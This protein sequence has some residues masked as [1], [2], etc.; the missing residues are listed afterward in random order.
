MLPARAE[1]YYLRR[2]RRKYACRGKG[3]LVSIRTYLG[4]RVEV[5]GDGAGAHIVLWPRGRISEQTVVTNA[6]SRGVGAYGISPYYL[7]RPPR[8]GIRLGYSRLREPQIREGIRRLA[9]VI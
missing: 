2:V 7:K 4:E 8:T 6:A 3:L 9:E 5:T 1:S